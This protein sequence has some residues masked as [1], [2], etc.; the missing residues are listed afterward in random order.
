MRGWKLGGK[1]VESSNLDKNWH[2][3]STWKGIILDLSNYSFHI[4]LIYHHR[5]FLWWMSSHQFLLPWHYN[6]SCAQLSPVERRQIA[7]EMIEELNQLQLLLNHCIFNV[8]YTQINQS[9]E[10]WMQ[11]NQIIYIRKK[12]LWMRKNCLF[13]SKLIDFLWCLN[14]YLII[15]IIT[16]VPNQSSSSLSSSTSESC[17]KNNQYLDKGK[18]TAHKS[19]IS[20]IY[21]HQIV[22]LKKIRQQK[23]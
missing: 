4:F 13:S 21:V 12:K 8:T 20:I 11:N 23:W 15:I 18:M 16:N 17:S 22:L 10:I 6:L 2:M 5:Q 7:G 1:P 14:I 3:N 19:I 9:M